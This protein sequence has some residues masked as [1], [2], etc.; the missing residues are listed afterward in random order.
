MSG[1]LHRRLSYLLVFFRTSEQEHQPQEKV[2]L[3]SYCSLMHVRYLFFPLFSYDFHFLVML[4]NCL[5]MK[6]ICIYDHIQ[7]EK[8]THQEKNGGQIR[9]KDEDIEKLN[10]KWQALLK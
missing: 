5:H 7:N 4:W 1:L 8:V 3:I 10:I 6:K 9:A 2:D